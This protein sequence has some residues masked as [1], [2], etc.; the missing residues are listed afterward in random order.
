[1]DPNAGLKL[2]QRCT[3]GIWFESPTYPLCERCSQQEAP[4]QSEPAE[5]VEGAGKDPAV[6]RP[7]GKRA[8]DKRDKGSHL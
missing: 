1:M 4:A 7:R 2:C 6:T 8:A 3:A 5:T